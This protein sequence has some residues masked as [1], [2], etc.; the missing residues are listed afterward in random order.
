MRGRLRYA[1][2][3]ASQGSPRSG[4]ARLRL[5]WHD[6]IVHALLNRGGERCQDCGRDY[7]IWPSSIAQGYVAFDRVQI[8]F[9]DPK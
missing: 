7:P 3:Q 2:G 6:F 5:L 4:L 8:D 1:F 9:Q